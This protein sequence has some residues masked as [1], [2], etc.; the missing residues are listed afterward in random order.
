[1]SN[2]ARVQYAVEEYN[3]LVKLEATLQKRI[4][5]QKDRLN[6]IVDQL[7]TEQFREWVKETEDKD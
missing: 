5:L 1:M 2:D 6:K 7:T 3:K 4:R